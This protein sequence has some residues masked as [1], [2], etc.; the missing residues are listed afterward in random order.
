LHQLPFTGTVD[1]KKRIAQ[2]K[3]SSLFQHTVT[4]EVGVQA[5]PVEVLIPQIYR[6][7]VQLANM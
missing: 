2:L 4:M 6:A 1:W 7:A 5:V 3:K